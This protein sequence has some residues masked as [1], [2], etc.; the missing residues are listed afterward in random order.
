MILQGQV[1]IHN[2]FLS[3]NCTIQIGADHEVFLKYDFARS[4]RN[5]QFFSF[6]CAHSTC[7][8]D[9]RFVDSLL[10]FFA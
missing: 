1:G 6:P 2:F 7:V 5:S 4:G 10:R 8:Q 3:Q 9:Q